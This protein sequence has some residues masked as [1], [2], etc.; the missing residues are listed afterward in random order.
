MSVASPVWL[1][2]GGTGQLGRALCSELSAR[3]QTHLS[4]AR[5]DADINCDIR[6]AQALSD[7]IKLAK[8]DIVVNCAAL[9]NLQLCEG[10]PDLAYA[11]NTKPV[12]TIVNALAKTNAKFVQISTDHVYAGEGPIAH[13]ETDEIYGW[14]MY[15]RSKILAEQIILNNRKHVSIRTNFTS[16]VKCGEKQTFCSWII[17]TAKLQGS[18]PGFTDAYCSL[19]P[20]SVAASAIVDLAISDVSGIYNVGAADVFSKADFIRTFLNTANIN[21]QV[22]QTSVTSLTPARVR[23]A[24]MD[25]SKAQNV[26]KWPL[27]NLQSVC[28]ELAGVEI[29]NEI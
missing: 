15:A 3:K 5:S 12:E 13:P 23:A 9:I 7:A 26:L 17:D 1:I 27:P 18:V 19:L 11:V 21:A 6:D 29:K 28:A 14:N 24:G 2:I 25:S 22:I 10:D 4:L 16:H 8:P 20:V